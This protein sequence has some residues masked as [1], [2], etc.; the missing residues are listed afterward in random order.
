LLKKTFA[1]YT[2]SF[3]LYSGVLG[4]LRAKTALDWAKFIGIPKQHPFSTAM[5]SPSRNALGGKN[6]HCVMLQGFLV[7]NSLIAQTGLLNVNKFL[8]LMNVNVN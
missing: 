4:F 6:H 5:H 3:P 1:S 7:G 2:T 8:T